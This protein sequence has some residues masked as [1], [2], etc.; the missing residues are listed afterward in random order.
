M[1]VCKFLPGQVKRDLTSEQKVHPPHLLHPPHFLQ[2]PHFLH[3]LTSYTPLTSYNPLTSYTP[4]YSYTTPYSYTPPYFLLP[5]PTWPLLSFTLSHFS[6]A[7]YLTLPHF[8]FAFASPCAPLHRLP[9]PPPP[10]P[11]PL[12]CP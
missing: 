7:H 8:Y 3:P 11:P 6:F 12:T 10:A 2:P 4:P 1:E 9:P 5:Y